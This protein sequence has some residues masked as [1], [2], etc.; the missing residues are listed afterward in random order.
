MTDSSDTNSAEYQEAEI[1]NRDQYVHENCDESLFRPVVTLFSRGD[2]DGKDHNSDIIENI[3]QPMGMGSE[4]IVPVMEEKVIKKKIDEEIVIKKT[5]KKIKSI[6][7]T[8]VKE[9]VKSIKEPVKLIK[10][11]IQMIDHDDLPIQ[12]VFND[13]S[14]EPLRSV[15]T[16]NE[17]VIDEYALERKLKEASKKIKEKTPPPIVTVDE[18]ILNKKSTKK[19]KSVLIDSD[20]DEPIRKPFKEKSPAVE[21]PIK[22]M[23]K[24]KENFEESIITIEEP[25]I[26]EPEVSVTIKL[27]KK[28]EK[29]KEEIKPKPKERTKMTKK[30]DDDFVT[31][32][33]L[34]KKDF[35][36]IDIE[37]E[38]EIH[39]PIKTFSEMFKASEH[40]TIQDNLTKNSDFIL[41]TKDKRRGSDFTLIEPEDELT[42]DK[43]IKKLSKSKEQEQFFDTSASKFDIDFTENLFS[44]PLPPLES[45]V[46][47]LDQLNFQED[48]ELM[49][50]ESTI[51]QDDHDDD[52]EKDEIVVKTKIMKYDE[53]NLI[54]ADCTSLHGEDFGEMDL[55]IGGRDNNSSD[56]TEDSNSSNEKK[57]E[58]VV[59]EK[60]NAKNILEETLPDNNQQ[61]I[62]QQSTNT[63]NN[64][65]KKTKKK[66][67]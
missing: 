67:R 10:E 30:F 59:N 44:K 63:N 43:P 14:Q 41:K 17:P 2:I 24:I 26:K 38:V 20:F 6:K 18:I 8:T 40:F 16:V 27:K 64:N 54:F 52:E 34:E 55:A 22:K 25:L 1:I 66:K 62:K 11:I 12:P 49:N 48:S 39:P 51:H 21:E 31:I 28:S 46:D 58:E 19:L 50:F 45:F 35:A 57:I 5:S 65:K 4:L 23:K 42:A 32:P 37:D 15:I 36:I 60:N 7:T 9:P 3:E 47:S 61:D 56:D 13:I 53:T 29:Q 33:R